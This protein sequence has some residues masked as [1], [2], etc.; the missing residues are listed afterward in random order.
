MNAFF[1]MIWSLFGSIWKFS[2]DM[3]LLLWRTSVSMNLVIAGL[4]VLASLLA[5]LRLSGCADRGAER[6]G[7][8]KIDN[9]GASAS[10]SDRVGDSLPLL[11]QGTPLSQR[12]EKT[13][14]DTTS[15]V[16]AFIITSATPSEQPLTACDNWFETQIDTMGVTILVRFNPATG[17]WKF[18]VYQIEYTLHPVALPSLPAG[19]FNDFAK[20]EI[21]E[22]RSEWRIGLGYKRLWAE[23]GVVARFGWGKEVMPGWGVYTNLEGVYG[24]GSKKLEPAF[25][26][27][28]NLGF[29]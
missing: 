24:F 7:I 14:M 10:L 16:K 20:S 5:G 9:S 26:A 22:R 23:N 2:R 18:K 13:Q 17:V 15:R 28:V 11:G 27:G 29:Y 4:L 3:F 8:W 6:K 21:F 19:K 25:E 1:A 12:G